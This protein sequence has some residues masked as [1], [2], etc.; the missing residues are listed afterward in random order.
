[1]VKSI[2]FGFAIAAFVSCYKTVSEPATPFDLVYFLTNGI[3]WSIV[4][5]FQIAI[6]NWI[7]ARG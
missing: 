2:I 1:M 5:A 7:S 3:F 4:I 6:L